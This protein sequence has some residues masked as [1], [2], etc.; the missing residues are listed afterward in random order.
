MGIIAGLGRGMPGRP[1]PRPAGGRGGRWSPSTTSRS[2][3][4][5]GRRPMPW[6]AANGLLPG[7]GAPGR[8]TGRGAGPGVLGRADE[9]EAS[10]VS[11]G[12]V[13]VSK[14]VSAA[15]GAAAAA[16]ASGVV[17][18]GPGLGPGVAAGA[19]LGGRGLDGR[20]C[21]LGRG[22]GRR[23]RGCRLGGRLHRRLLGRL[24]SGRLGGLGGQ[25]GVAVLL[26]ELHLDGKLDRRGRRLDELA[27][28]LQLLEHFLALDAIGLGEL[29]NS[30]LGHFSPSGRHPVQGSAT[31]TADVQNS[32]RSTHRVLM[33]CCS[34]FCRSCVC[35]T[36]LTAVLSSGRGVRATE[37]LRAPPRPAGPG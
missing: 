22:G 12:S 14:S 21:G 33:S 2:G 28:L 6:L 10:E 15:A 20:C 1:S 34:S 3:P 4:G 16:G 17:V 7:R 35:A 31:V 18:R 24:G 8:P 27:H 11:D 29:M 5:A 25:Q 23:R 19:C 36:W 13:P 9:S 30:G 37:R 32:S 26:L